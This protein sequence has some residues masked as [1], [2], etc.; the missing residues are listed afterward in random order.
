MPFVNSLLLYK[1]SVL[2]AQ[3]YSNGCS[4]MRL[5]FLKRFLWN[6]FKFDIFSANAHIICTYIWEYIECIDSF[7]YLVYSEC[8]Y[9]FRHILQFFVEKCFPYNYLDKNLQPEYNA[10]QIPIFV[11]YN[12]VVS[13]NNWKLL[14]HC[15]RLIYWGMITRVLNKQVWQE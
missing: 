13:S 11:R 1:S 9:S 7:R 8:M 14:F 6:H 12:D 10:H 4:L 3:M 5:I 15:Y 2:S